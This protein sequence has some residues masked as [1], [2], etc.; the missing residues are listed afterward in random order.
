MGRKLTHYRDIGTDH[1]YQSRLVQ[2]LIN[3]V[4]Q[5]G[6]KTTA[7]KIVYDAFEIIGEQALDTFNQ[8]IENLSPEAEVRYKKVGGSTCA[9]PRQPNGRRAE[10]LA[11][12]WL[13]KAVRS[14]QGK[15][16]SQLL[17]AEITAASKNEGKA[18]DEKLQLHKLAESNRAYAVLNW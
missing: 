1:Q 4:M 3:K 15:P 10:F 12:N 16:V 7:E 18:Y 13:L 2:A 11:F 14:G 8:A 6:K 17:A 5:D 9:V